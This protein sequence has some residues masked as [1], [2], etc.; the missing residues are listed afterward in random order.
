[1]K[2]FFLRLGEGQNPGKPKAY[3]GGQKGVQGG[4]APMAGG[5]GG[6][7]LSDLTP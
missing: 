4:E 6:V 5:V 2:L 1:M 3:E 7:P